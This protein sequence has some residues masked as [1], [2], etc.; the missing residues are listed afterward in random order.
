M[1]SHGRGLAKLALFYGVLLIPVIGP[2]IV[3]LAAIGLALGRRGPNRAL[4]PK[5]RR[6]AKARHERKK[7]EYLAKIGKN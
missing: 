2:P 7:A 4:T 1:F 5:E 3:A 6:L